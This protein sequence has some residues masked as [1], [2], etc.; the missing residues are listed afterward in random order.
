[1]SPKNGN[2]FHIQMIIVV[3][4]THI[5][6]SENCSPKEGKIILFSNHITSMVVFH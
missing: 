2:T 6:Y 4:I 5:P 3:N 1:M